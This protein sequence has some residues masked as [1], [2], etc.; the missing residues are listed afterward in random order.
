MAASPYSARTF[1]AAPASPAG[2][3]GSDDDAAFPH[4]DVF[5]FP[6][7]AMQSQAFPVLYGRQGLAGCADRFTL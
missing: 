7:N 5:H 6:F 3:S 1:A 4:A 2:S